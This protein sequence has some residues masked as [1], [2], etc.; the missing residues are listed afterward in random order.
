MAFVNANTAAKNII[1]CRYFHKLKHIAYTLKTPVLYLMCNAGI[2][3]F[4]NVIKNNNKE[5]DEFFE[6]LSD[7]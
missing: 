7:I 2:T 1:L 4:D 3:V 6:M 5:M